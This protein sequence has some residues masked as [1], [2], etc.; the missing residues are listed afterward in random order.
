MVNRA[1]HRWAALPA[2][3]LQL[4]QIYKNNE[5]L[6]SF[7]QQ[8]RQKKRPSSTFLMNFSPLQNISNK[9]RLS[10]SRGHCQSSWNELLRAGSKGARKPKTVDLKK[11]HQ[12]ER[13]QLF[14]MSSKKPSNL[15]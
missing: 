5:K 4:K 13:A 3:F 12:D 15:A 2:R 9:P 6:G 8:H 7:V 14:A 11:S 10:F 1:P